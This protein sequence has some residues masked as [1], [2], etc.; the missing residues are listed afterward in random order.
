MVVAPRL[1]HNKHGIL[2]FPEPREPVG[3]LLNTGIAIPG[4]LCKGRGSAGLTV[5]ARTTPSGEDGR[6]CFLPQALLANARFGVEFYPIHVVL[7]KSFGFC[8]H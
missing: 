4:E 2:P 3:E 5:L 6:G 1:A 8:S 7:V